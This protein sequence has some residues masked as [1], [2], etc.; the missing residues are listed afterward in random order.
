MSMITI[1]HNF[2][3]MNA[4]R[5]LGITGG[6]ISK[7]SEKL[8]SG[9]KI[10]RA[11]DDAAGL[12]ISEKMRRQI[13][14]LAQATRNVQEGNSL[15][16]VADSAL[17]EMHDIMHRMTQL[18]VQSANG[19]N[20]DVD[21]KALDDEYQQLMKELNSIANKTTFNEIKLLDGHL[22]DYYVTAELSYDVRPSVEN[23]IA[24]SVYVSYS[25]GPPAALS[26]LSYNYSSFSTPAVPE[27]GNTVDTTNDYTIYI[28]DED[29]EIPYTDYTNATPKQLL[30]DKNDVT[31]K[32][33]GATVL[34]AE[35]I[36]DTAPAFTNQP[37]ATR[38][39][40]SSGSLGSFYANQLYVTSSAATVDSNTGQIEYNS[41]GGTITV[42]GNSVGGQ[43]K[44]TQASE[45][46]INNNSAYAYSTTTSKSGIDDNLNGEFDEYYVYDH[47]DSDGKYVYNKYHHEE[48]GSENGS[49]VS[50]GYYATYNYKYDGNQDIDCLTYTVNGI[51]DS[52][53]EK[54]TI[55][56]N[57]GYIRTTSE[58]VT[59][60]NN[61]GR[62]DLHKSGD[63][64]TATAI[65]TNNSGTIRANKDMTS[66]E[67]K[68]NS[69]IIFSA[70]DVTTVNKMTSG[71]FYAAHGIATIEDFDGG[72]AFSDSGA[73][74]KV[75]ALG[76]GSGSD[77]VIHAL[78]GSTVEVNESKADGKIEVLAGADVTVTSNSGEIRNRST[79]PPLVVENNSGIIHNYGVINL[80]ELETNSGSIYHHIT[81]IDTSAI[82]GADAKTKDE[83]LG[84][85]EV[86]KVTANGK[87]YTVEAHWEFIG[88]TSSAN[89]DEISGYQCREEMGI[90]EDD[91]CKSTSVVIADQFR[92]VFDLKTAKD[93]N[94][95]YLPEGQAVVM[96]GFD[97]M[98]DM[99][100]VLSGSV[101]MSGGTYES[102][103]YNSYYDYYGNGENGTVLSLY[104]STSADIA[105]NEGSPL[106]IQA[107]AEANQHI[108][109][110]IND[111]HP[112]A[113]AYKPDDCDDG[114]GCIS[115]GETNILTVDSS[116]V[117]IGAVKSAVSQISLIRAN[118]GAY[119]N[120]FEHTINN[121]QNVVEN[122][123]CAESIIRHTDVA[124]EMLAYSNSQ[125]LSQAGNSILAQAN[126]SSQVLLGLLQ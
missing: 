38:N 33:Y 113:F 57:S 14:G 67:V 56:E 63:S 4:N 10:N 116:D 97:G 100:C 59:A 47:T 13:R 50:D 39:Y 117:A 110:S 82:T 94:G 55:E 119:Q 111:C 21:R 23:Q 58:S 66:L 25:S 86:L 90:C 45:A 65:I 77:A 91:C 108:D 29:E 7:S 95:D 15:V 60:K 44:I 36:N 71:R 16:Q 68:S 79:A 32:N 5:E 49:L 81:S 96:D 106:P 34:S 126:Q 51:I 62:L 19:T 75:T 61:S 84:L 3:A 30:V 37:Y 52:Y 121:L 124:T 64:S 120:R 104:L 41:S 76:N 122:V 109:I 78:A 18:S 72:Y 101:T 115:L 20:T 54:T 22:G 42:N 46:K 107:G 98:D 118:L 112:G 70:A 99:R 83:I 123:S 31:I 48:D 92:L 12:A 87:D 40:N 24:K 93:E 103:G 73:T 28:E 80:D 125:I 74:L 2:M 88:D 26:K 89:L 9:Y 35:K 102:F 11:A 43:I 27:D 85:N 6:K 69:Y 53:A 1:A 17:T 8:S 114:C 105:L